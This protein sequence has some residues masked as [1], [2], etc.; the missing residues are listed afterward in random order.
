MVNNNGDKP[1]KVL[2]AEI[3]DPA[4]EVTTSESKPGKQFVVALRIPTG[5]KVPEAGRTVVIK[6]DDP[7][8]KELKVRVNGP[9]TASAK[10]TP[11]TRPAM[12]ML[13]QPAPTFSLKTIDDQPVGAAEFKSYPATVLNFVA[14]NCGYCK[15]QLPLVDPVRANYEPRGVRFVNMMET[16]RQEFTQ[17]QIVGVM[18]DVGSKSPIAIDKGN[19]VGKQFKV[20]SFPSLFI[21]DKNGKIVEVV[22][23]RKDNIAV[24][25]S[26]RLDELLKSEAGGSTAT[27]TQPGAKPLTQATGH[28]GS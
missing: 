22:V 28:S 7:E 19:V 17:D 12:T 8:F 6:T 16:M 26:R 5:Y 1:F 11:T 3:D 18:N 10:K 23:G 4:V 2:G 13:N 21:I 20:S 25:M 14:P 27:T 15:K 24:T 9:K